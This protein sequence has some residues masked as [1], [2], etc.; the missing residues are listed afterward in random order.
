MRTGEEEKQK[1]RDRERE[2]IHCKHKIE[3]YV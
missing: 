1:T 3:T 2:K